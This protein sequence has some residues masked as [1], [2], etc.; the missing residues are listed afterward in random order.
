[1]HEARLTVHHRGVVHWGSGVPVARHA[2]LAWKLVI[3]IDAPLSFDD[4]R[5]SGSCRALFV[6][7]GAAHAITSRSETMEILVDPGS[8]GAPLATRGHTLTP[9]EG[10][11]AD[12]LSSIAGVQDRDPRDDAERAAEAFRALELSPQRVDVRVSE[13]LDR[14]ARD[15]DL[16][17]CE[18]LARRKISTER[19]RHLVFE[20]TGLALRTHRLWYRM[21]RGLEALLEGGTVSSAAA[22]SGFADHAHFTRTF[23]RFV[24][25]TP[26]SIHG[27]TTLVSSYVDRPSAPRWNV[28]RSPRARSGR[29]HSQT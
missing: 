25:R 8:E 19:L 5:T 26:S 13:V 17:V 10:R 14:V 4:G 18:L 22:R 3:A 7:P 16:D 29:A 11:L 2:S 28:G 12:R 21:L 15:P 1:M 20:S 24:G 6:P 27:R 9:I 23:V